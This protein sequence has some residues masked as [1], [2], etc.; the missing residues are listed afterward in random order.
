MRTFVVDY[1]MMKPCSSFNENVLVKRN[2]TKRNEMILTLITTDSWR[3]N[4]RLINEFVV[5]L[6]IYV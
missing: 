2:L 4:E 1:K 5:Y 3:V 6:D